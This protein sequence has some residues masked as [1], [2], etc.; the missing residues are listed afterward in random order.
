MKHLFILKDIKK[1]HDFAIKIKAIMHNYNYQIVYSHSAQEMKKY[2]QN[3]TTPCRIYIAG[4]D[5]TVH[6]IIQVLTHTQHE[7]VILPLGTG[8]DFSYTLTK[9]KNPARILKQSLHKQAK[10]VDTI[11]INDQYYINSACF[12]VDSVIANHVHDTP[13]IPL[14][15]E[16]KSYIISILQHVFRYRFHHVKVM[17][18]NQCLYN[19]PITLCTFN[20]GQYYGGGFQIT[21]QASI[22]DGYIDVCIVDQV[23]KK[24]IPYLV[25]L[26]VA[27]QIAH[28]PEVHYYQVKEADIFCDYDS[29][30]DGELYQ[31]HHYHIEI[32]PLSIQIVY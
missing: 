2:A 10:L 19:G 12:G 27:H 23:P 3:L 32:Q 15:P 4:G 7:L 8:N 9:E 31:S 11:L 16:S 6:D 21:P 30:I 17:S 1:H 14:V 22:N 18:Q 5:G 26:L 13:D 28:R 24:R 25:S 20:N 29:N